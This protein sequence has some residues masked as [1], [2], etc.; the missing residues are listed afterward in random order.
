[1]FGVSGCGTGESTIHSIGSFDVN[2]DDSEIRDFRNLGNERAP[3]SLP[4]N[5]WL[6]GSSPLLRRK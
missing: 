1:M 4:Q 3:E 6:A 5:H 2:L